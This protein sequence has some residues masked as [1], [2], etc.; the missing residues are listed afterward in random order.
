MQKLIDS[1]NKMKKKDFYKS[2]EFISVVIILLIA[3]VLLLNKIKSNNELFHNGLYSVGEVTDI[4]IMKGGRLYYYKFKN[5]GTYHDGNMRS[6]VHRN[7][8]DKCYVIYNPNNLEQNNMLFSLPLVSDSIY[9]LNKTWKELPINL[10]EEIIK[11]AM[12]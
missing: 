5:N 6:G 1:F 2:Y 4:D 11:E 12:Q 7:I 9:A 8:G 10:D 3:L